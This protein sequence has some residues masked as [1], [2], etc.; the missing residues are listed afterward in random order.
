MSIRVQEQVAQQGPRHTGTGQMDDPIAHLDAKPTKKVRGK[1]GLSRRA[2]LS[3]FTIFTYARNDLPP[4]TLHVLDAS[5]AGPPTDRERVTHLEPAK[6]EDTKSHN[7]L[8]ST[9]RTDFTEGAFVIASE[10]W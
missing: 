1:R 4:P 6:N 5:K 7:K 10:I 2:G 8:W 3:V 9:N